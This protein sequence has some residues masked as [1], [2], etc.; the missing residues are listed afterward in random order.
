MPPKVSVVIPVYNRPVAV[1]RAID[2]VLAQTVKDF[3]IIVVDDASSDDTV[4][5][6]TAYADPRITL[7]RHDRNRGGSAARNTGF[8]AG[9][10]RYVAFLDSDDEWL[11][12]K[13]EKQLEVFE[14]SNDDL[15][16]VYVGTERIFADG[17]I[18]RDVP[19]RHEN[20]ARELLTVNV[21]GET[22]VGMVRRS[23][24]DA[25]NGFDEELPASQDMDL[26][27]RICERF[28]ADIVPEVLVRVVKADDRGRIT[29]SV[30]STT[31]GRELFRRKHREKLA[32]HGVLYSH[33]RE[34]GLWYQRGARDNRQAR[35]CYLESIAANPFAPLTYLLLLVTYLPIGWLNR[36]VLWK[37]S[38]V[39]AIQPTSAL[40]HD[41]PREAETSR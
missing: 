30:A 28:P 2:S 27:L 9:T 31:R 8:R 23:A 29:A 7:I 25:V 1:R 33:L 16:L 24:L 12:A 34:S 17:L 3:E 22:S 32:R 18:Q 13:L 14:R 11:P 41:N 5:S 36:V 26:W 20:L 21:V 40:L 10:A 37:R 39:N 4:A 15:A 19:R 6:V 35:R 38:V